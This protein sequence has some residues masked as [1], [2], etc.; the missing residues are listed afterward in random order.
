MG[1]RNRFQAEGSRTKVWR[2]REQVLS[3]FVIT[4]QQ[5]QSREVRG[6]FKRGI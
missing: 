5:D 4:V 2:E 6:K 3:G 1:G